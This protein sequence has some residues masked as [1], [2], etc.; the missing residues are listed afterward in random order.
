MKWWRWCAGCL[1]SAVAVMNREA[2]FLFFG[3]HSWGLH[4]CPVFNQWHEDSPSTEI[5]WVPYSIFKTA[6]CCLAGRNLW[7]RVA[8]SRWAGGTRG[9]IIQYG[10]HSLTLCDCWICKICPVTIKYKH[11]CH[12]LKI[13]YQGCKIFLWWCLIS[14]TCGS[15]GSLYFR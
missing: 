6:L 4:T 12:I 7:S 14:I 9:S 1:Y 2:S 13:Q 3:S 10:G 8:E 15:S 11:A 5:R